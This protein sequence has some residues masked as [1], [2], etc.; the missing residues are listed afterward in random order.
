MRLHQPFRAHKC[1]PEALKKSICETIRKSGI[2]V[3]KGQCDGLFLQDISEKSVNT[4]VIARKDSEKDFVKLRSYYL[5]SPGIESIECKVWEAGRATSVSRI[6]FP[7][8]K[9][10]DAEVQFCDVGES[11]YNPSRHALGEARRLWKPDVTQDD[12][13]IACFLSIGT[14]TAD[15]VDKWPKDTDLRGAKVGSKVTKTVEYH[16]EI[17]S[18]CEDTHQKF[19][20]EEPSIRSYSRLNVPD[21]GKLALDEHKHRQRILEET[22]KYLEDHDIAASIKAVVQRLTETKPDV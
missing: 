7:P 18:S 15:R 22:N 8:F 16:L 5:P 21:I 13:Q 14:G 10:A 11:V 4:V 6:Y 17:I 2:Q 1:N 3:P 9:L 20:Y 19:I 12:V